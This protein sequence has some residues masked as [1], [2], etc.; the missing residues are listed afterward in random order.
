[1]MQDVLKFSAKTLLFLIPFGVIGVLSF[2]ALF[3]D[4]AYTYQVL[5][6]YQLQKLATER[7][8]ETIVVGDSSGGNA[9]DAEYFSELT[10]TET[11][12]LALNGLYGYA[13]S[14]NMIRKALE[15]SPNLKN[16]IVVQS[17]DMMQRPISYQGY[18]YSSASFQD[19]WEEGLNE[20]L[21]TAFFDSIL[22]SIG[23]NAIITDIKGHARPIVNDYVVQEGSIESPEIFEWNAGKV[24]EDKLLFL[25]KIRQLCEERDLN[26]IY[27]HGPLWEP[28]ALAS[29]E[30]FD[31]VERLIK[32][33]N[34]VMIDEVIPIKTED[35]GNTID[36]VVPDV[37][38]IYTE[39][40]AE[41]VFPY[42]QLGSQ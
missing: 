41:A 21:I 24:K 15:A 31:E 18:L 17:A 37:K 38:P 28:I 39:R 6:H 34:I 9:I 30:Y 3:L 16:V 22:S 14:Y 7:T 25:I 2:K 26:L 8:F 27:V 32:A 36:H 19:V 13:G 42:L 5:Y 10:G 35:L 40:Y 11:V 20:P 1:M 12:N 4:E 23:T 29:E 33:Q